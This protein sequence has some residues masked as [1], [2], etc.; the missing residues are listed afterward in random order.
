MAS[1]PE[2]SQQAGLITLDQAAKLL[3]LTPNRIRQL[4][5]EGA[6]PKPTRKMYPLVGVVQGYVKFLRDE[7]RRSS[8]VAAESGLKAARQ[9]EIEIRIAEKRRELVA[10]P[11]AEMAMTA[12]CG[13]IN[14]EFNGFAARVTRDI[15]TRREIEK[16]LNVSLNRIADQLDAG[17]VAL[18]TGGAPSSAFA[19]DDA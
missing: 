18:A 10:R 11:E 1:P 8:K 19:E 7:D 2:T 15:P 12:L 6:L 14:E 3:M 4:V 9:S 13:R 5:A 16:H 17:Q